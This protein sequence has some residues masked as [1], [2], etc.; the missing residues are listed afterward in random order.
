MFQL[1]IDREKTTYGLYGLCRSLLRTWNFKIVW[2]Y[3]E[4]IRAGRK[5]RGIQGDSTQMGGD[6]VIDPHCVVRFAYRSHDPT[7]RP[8]IETLMA[9]LKTLGDDA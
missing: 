3:V 6:F 4:L 9:V 2:S 5:W 1:L 7:D 8:A